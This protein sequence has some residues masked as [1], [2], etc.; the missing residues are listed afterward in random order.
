M[1]KLLAIDPGEWTGY[2][3]YQMQKLVEAGVLGKGRAEIQGQLRATLGC[4]VAAGRRPDEAVIEIPQVYR[5]RQQKGDPND[6]ISVAIIAGICNSLIYSY[7]Y[8]DV[9]LIHPREWKGQRPKDVDNRGILETLS[10]EEL[11]I[12][13]A[14]KLPKSKA[15]NVVDAIGIGL[16]ELGRR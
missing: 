5:Q 11:R 8:C 2:A 7:T 13:E 14:L 16:W 10:Q 15:H 6:L 3:V 1:S 12:F 4:L 9:D